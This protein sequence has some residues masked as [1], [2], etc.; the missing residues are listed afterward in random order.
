MVESCLDTWLSVDLTEATLDLD[1]RGLELDCQKADRTRFFR[2]GSATE[3]SRATVNARSGVRQVA[4]DDHLSAILDRVQ[5]LLDQP[6]DTRR[7]MPATP[8]CQPTDD[9][10][11]LRLLVTSPE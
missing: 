8:R 4:D 3:A 10:D 5:Q 11:Q 1:R 2:V 9:R 7:T 6:F